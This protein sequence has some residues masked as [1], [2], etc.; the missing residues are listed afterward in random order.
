MRQT[1]QSLDVMALLAINGAHAPWLDAVMVFASAKLVWV[2]LY[3]LL[4]AI[5]VRQLGWKNGLYACLILVG[6]VALS[7]QTASALLKPMFERLRPCHQPSLRGLLHLPHGCGGQFG[8]ASSHAANTFCVATFFI[9][10]FCRKF[11]WMGGLAVW[12]FVVSYS[13]IYLAAH[14]PSDVLIG[15]LIGVAWA[16]VGIWVWAKVQ[17]QSSQLLRF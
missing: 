13:R 9:F 10:L 12:A 14:Y 1:L 2:P 17:G 16:R 7:D 6:A 5:T 8:F 11:W 15:G 4:I 3:I